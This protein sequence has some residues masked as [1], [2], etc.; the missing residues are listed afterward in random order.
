MSFR[1]WNRFAATVTVPQVHSERIPVRRRARAFRVWVVFD[2]DLGYIARSDTDAV[3]YDE[4]VLC[5]VRHC[6]SK[7]MPPEESLELV[8]LKSD[9][10]VYRNTFDDVV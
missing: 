1:L 6:L 8:D 3:G 9:R 5:H 7:R 2:D 10:F 4:V